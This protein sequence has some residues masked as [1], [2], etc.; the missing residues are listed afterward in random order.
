MDKNDDKILFSDIASSLDFI[1]FL[2]DDNKIIKPI[3]PD[4][5]MDLNLISTK[6][7]LFPN[8]YVS[9]ST[10]NNYD[11]DILKDAY[12]NSKLIGV[13]CQKP[14]NKDIY[15]VGTISQILKLVNVSENKIQVVLQG[16]N[17][18]KI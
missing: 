15:S 1:K 14:N 13:V 12:N 6:N 18:F 2:I 16:I 9:I 3:P 7:V 5:V 17:K 8:I 10:S 4:T 11:I